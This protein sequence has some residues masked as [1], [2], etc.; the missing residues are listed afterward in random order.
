MTR[1]PREPLDDEERV[2][3]ARL[4]RPHG[5]D[6]PG[7]GIDAAI[8]AAAHAATIQPSGSAA[9]RRRWLVPAGLAASLCLAAGLAWRVQFM[10]PARS[11]APASMEVQ[12]SARA[13][14]AGTSPREDAVAA[15]RSRSAPDA[16]PAASHQAPAA[17]P[18]PLA[19]N[20]PQ[21]EAVPP[22]PSRALPAPHPPAPAPA[23]APAPAAP[24]ATL[25]APPAPPAPPPPHAPAGA[26]AE[27]LA[28]PAA[29]RAA[30][31]AQPTAAA[32]ARTADSAVPAQQLAADAPEADIPPATADAPEVRDAWLRRIGEL[33]REGRTAEARASLAEFRRRFPAAPVPPALRA[34]EAPAPEPESR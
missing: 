19:A 31:P 27:A 8:L 2:L 4:P 25:P 11:P 17:R 13:P 26:A 14:A 16:A 22:P 21:R 30:P 3:A 5:R 7:A 24:L 9:P 29:A 1:F 15:P 20:A 12:Q 23:V 34:L 33:Q 6:E 32:K 28:A 18:R 10:P